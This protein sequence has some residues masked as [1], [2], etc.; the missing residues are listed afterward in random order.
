MKLITVS[1]GDNSLREYVAF[2]G[3]TRIEMVYGKMVKAEGWNNK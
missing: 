1:T 3:G 2:S